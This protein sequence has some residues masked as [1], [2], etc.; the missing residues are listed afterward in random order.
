M[1]TGCHV[2]NMRVFYH[3]KG[4]GTSPGRPVLWFRVWRMKIHLTSVGPQYLLC[5]HCPSIFPLLIL[6]LMTWTLLSINKETV[7]HKV[8]QNVNKWRHPIQQSEVL[9]K[10]V[11]WFFSSGS[12][13]MLLSSVWISFSI[14]I[15]LLLLFMHFAF[16]LCWQQCQK[17][18]AS[19]PTVYQT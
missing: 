5:P 6:S 2:E 14:F 11:C 10:L 1:E 18:K 12:C 19:Q 15:L 9:Q 4:N 16:S 17:Y 8:K 7:G 13:W 3:P